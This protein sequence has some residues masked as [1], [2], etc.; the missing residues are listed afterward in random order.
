MTILVTGSAGFIGFHVAQ[1][2]L[3]RG[4]H[5]VGVDNFDPYYDVAL[6]RARVAML[7]N[8]PA[9]EQVELNIADRQAM[10]ALFAERGFE[11]VVHLAAQAGV[12]HSIDHPHD[13]IDS[14]VT[15]TLN[16]LEGCR[17]N[18]VA[19][20]V[21]A[22]TS[23]VYGASTDMPFSPSGDADHPLAIYAASK[24]ATELMAHSY[25]YLYGLPTTGLRFFT[26]YGP[27]GRP[28]MALF[29]FTRK[30]LAGEPIPVFNHGKHRRDFTFVD[31]IAEGIVRV[32]YKTATPD[33]NW[34]SDTPRVDSSPA[35]WRI[36]NI[37]NG[38]PVPLM[39]YI[40]RLEECLG[41]TAEKEML[42]MQ[43]GDIEATHADVHGLFE[44]VGYRPETTV[45]EGVKKFVDWYRSYYG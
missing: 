20:L 26:V 23:S 8:N 32:L 5:V 34:N 11:C 37:G 41:I 36:Y 16:I 28:D 19:H 25:S 12:R 31:D 27:W 42:P 13:Y 14:N 39:D 40:N 30:M 38:N 15:G 17:H 35:P 43:A 4:E 44:A 1:R 24:R 21:Y 6:K 7:E 10:P 33:E 9:F 22:S 29:L 3:D 2:L 18:N 45:D